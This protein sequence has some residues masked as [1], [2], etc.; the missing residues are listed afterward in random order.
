MPAVS[1]LQ[2]T[3]RMRELEVQCLCLPI[4][5]SLAYACGRAMHCSCTMMSDLALELCH[6]TQQ[7]AKVCSYGKTPASLCVNQFPLIN[8]SAAAENA[9]HSWAAMHAYLAQ[10]CS[11]ISCASLLVACRRPSSM[12]L[13][14]TQSQCPLSTG[15]MAHGFLAY[16]V[17]GSFTRA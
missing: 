1:S 11:R 10:A 13:A 17:D 6:A 12:T 9:W 15:L 5:L 2:N 14:R 4:H 7:Q 3:D 16:A 8:W